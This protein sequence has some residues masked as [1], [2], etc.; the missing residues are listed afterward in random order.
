MVEQIVRDYPIIYPRSDKH[1]R[2]NP[3]LLVRTINIPKSYLPIMKDLVKGGYFSSVSE[4]I[5]VAIR[6]F[7]MTQRMITE[8]V[9]SRIETVVKDIITPEMDNWTRRVVDDIIHHQ[10][11]LKDV[12]EFPNAKLKPAREPRRG[13]VRKRKGF[14][15][16]Y[17]EWEGH[18]AWV[19][20]DRYEE[21]N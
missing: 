1:S 20:I 21:E 19:T 4:I 7:F 3:E 14:I 16:E 6:D 9:N 11:F 10:K 17:R 13:D 12:A 8:V 15:Q 2:S 5:R 18:S